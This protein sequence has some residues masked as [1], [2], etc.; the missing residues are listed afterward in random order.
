[1]GSAT[2]EKCKSNRI[3]K[4]QMINRE[5]R[6]ELYSF[7]IYIY[8]RQI[9]IQSYHRTSHQKGEVLRSSLFKHF[10]SYA[11][12]TQTRS[13]KSILRYKS[14]LLIMIIFDQFVF[15][16]T[17]SADRTTRPN[18]TWEVNRSEND[19][20]LLL[21]APPNKWCTVILMIEHHTI[22]QYIWAWCSSS[23]SP[24]SEKMTW[25][26]NQNETPHGKSIVLSRILSH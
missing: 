23:T 26:Q 6:A 18:I 2:N 16:S 4:C 17:N 13:C 1:M 3:A 14:I 20:F 19:F 21:C 12:S 22:H 10:T 7:N 8:E 15:L 25:S 5:L 11:P 9:Q 24:M